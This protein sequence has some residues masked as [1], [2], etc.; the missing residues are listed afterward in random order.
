MPHNRFGPAGPHPSHSAIERRRKA[1]RLCPL[2]GRSAAAGRNVATNKPRE[3]ATPLGS[4]RLV[5]T[6]AR[7]TSKHMQLKAVQQPAHTEARTTSSP[8]QPAA[9]MATPPPTS[10]KK[11]LPWY[12]DMH[13]SPAVRF[14]VCV[15]VLQRTLKLVFYTC[16]KTFCRLHH[17]LRSQPPAGIGWEKQFSSEWIRP[18]RSTTMQQL[19][20]H[21]HKCVQKT[22]SEIPRICSAP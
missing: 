12:V 10:S 1:A 2:A 7:H 22:Y 3:H 17:C 16:N 19:P 21:V 8:H 14:L 11:R 6:R 15:C 9:T 20:K 13:A 5:H 4:P 18:D